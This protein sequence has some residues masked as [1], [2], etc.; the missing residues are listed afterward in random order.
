MEL[1]GSAFEVEFSFSSRWHK[2]CNGDNSSH[3][4]NSFAL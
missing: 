4:I 3:K 1:D 2:L